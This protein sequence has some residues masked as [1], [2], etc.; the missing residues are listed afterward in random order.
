MEYYTFIIVDIVN[1][2]NFLLPEIP[3]FFSMI[4]LCMGENI[5]LIILSTYYSG[6]IP[7]LGEERLV[8]PLARGRLLFLPH[9]RLQ[10][11]CRVSTPI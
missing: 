1:P 11:P 7:N 6:I 5:H 8:S 9:V 4:I 3:A 2:Q 10:V